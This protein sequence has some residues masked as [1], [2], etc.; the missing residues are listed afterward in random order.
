MGIDL[1]ENCDECYQAQL[2][3]FPANILFKA[4]L[5]ANTN[6][7][8]K[9]VDKFNNAFVSV[10]TMS[11]GSGNITIV[12]PNTWP[13]QWFNRNAGKFNFSFSKVA[14]PWAQEQ[15]L[16]GTPQNTYNCIEIE[17]AKDASETIVQ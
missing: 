8:L 13:P 2:N 11:D 7:F 1:L 3:E 14:Q 15:M 9:V 4:N 12:I 17:F 6:Y 10:Q 16:L 5:S